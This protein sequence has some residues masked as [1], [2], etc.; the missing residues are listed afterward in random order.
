M[1]TLLQANLISLGCMPTIAL[2]KAFVNN[3]VYANIATQ[4]AKLSG[5]V[6][7]PDFPS[8]ITVQNVY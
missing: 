3:V 1:S 4:S 6:N 5:L 8:P 2:N 7:G